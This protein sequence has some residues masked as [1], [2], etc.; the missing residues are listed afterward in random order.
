MRKYSLWPMWVL[1]LVSLVDQID[2]GI[3]RGVLPFLEDEWGLSDFELGLLG[4]SFVF[5]NTVAT[6]PA[7]WMADRWR[8]NRVMGWTLVSWSGLIL[9]SATAVNY[10]NLVAARAVMGIGQSV[11][12]PASTSLL[13]DFYPPRMRSRVF[14]T[15]QIAFFVGGGLG[16]A[17]GGYVA[18]ELSWRWA[19]AI[20]G[21]PGSVIAF[22]VF[23][24]REPVR[25]E[26]DLLEHGIDPARLGEEAAKVEAS[27]GP[28]PSLRQF[29]RTVVVDLKAELRMI[30]GIRTMRYILVGV[31]ALLFTVSGIA[32]W[33]AIYHDRYSDMT[34]KGAVA[35]T[36]AVLGIG[37]GIG[38]V[39]GGW[40][41]DRMA[42]TGGPSARIMQVVWSAM[43]CSGL[44]MISFAVP[45]VP[46]RLGLQFVGVAS[47][48]GAAPALR[49]AMMDVLPAESRGV[50]ASAF[51]LASAVFGTALAP[52]LVGLLSD[53]TG[54]LVAAFYI[55]FPPIIGGLLLLMRARTTIIDD[56]AV[57]MQALFAKAQAG[58]AQGPD[59]VPAPPSPDPDPAL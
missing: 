12:D 2:M 29:A 27:E 21:V 55:V 24:L 6:I 18:A 13:G 39:F 14:A 4:F 33:L 57:L 42:R 30:F 3:A 35:F 52:P 53:I 16:L 32:Y 31:S 23:K 28:A 34:E 56:A 7:G 41:S 46:L 8:R 58:G 54:S 47:A 36:A 9:L 50:G 59:P 22:L 10:W 43:G 17:L 44:F 48:A 11:D 15:Q 19:F 20:V 38:T 5:V 37:G 25:G 45:S 49:A 51:A 1:G 40:L 26:A